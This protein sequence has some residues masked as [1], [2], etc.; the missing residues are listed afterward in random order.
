[1]HFLNTIVQFFLIST[2]AQKQ[3]KINNKTM[4]QLTIYSNKN[5]LYII[6]SILL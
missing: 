1:M 3:Q 4:L 6:F 2:K 5:N